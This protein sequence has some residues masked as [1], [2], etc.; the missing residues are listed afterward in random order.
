MAKLAKDSFG[1]TWFP[2]MATGNTDDDN[3]YSNQVAIKYNGNLSSNV[4]KNNV[5]DNAVASDAV[6]NNNTDYSGDNSTPTYTPDKSSSDD[7]DYSWIQEIIN[8]STSNYADM[9]RELYDREDYLNSLSIEEAQKNRE[10]NAEQSKYAMDWSAQE[11]QK[12]REWQEEMSNTSHQREVAD[13][14]AAGLN[15]VLS[16]N[17]GAST[18]NGSS[19]Q[20][21][22]SSGSAANINNSSVSNLFGNVINAAV[23]LQGLQTSLLQTEMETAS[24]QIVAGT[25]AGATK[26]SADAS[27]RASLNSASRAY[28][29]SLLTAQ[30]S[31]AA[32]KYAADTSANA[33]K[34]SANQSYKSSIFNSLAGILKTVGLGM[35][36]GNTGSISDILNRQS[37]GYRY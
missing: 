13:L 35:S 1:N 16:V 14:K 24:N 34:Y 9:L 6:V 29:S 26:Y 30:S 12:N 19:G 22:A 37:K 36:F 4:T 2:S 31:K 27:E 5:G 32:S 3:D 20:G 10:W 7:S 21:Y 18:P 25:Y 28:Q 17:S 15:P 11:A 33:Y 23:Q 8:G